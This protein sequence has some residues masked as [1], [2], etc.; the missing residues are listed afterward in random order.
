[1]VQQFFGISPSNLEDPDT[2]A[3]LGAVIQVITLACSIYQYVMYYCR[4]VS[5]R[6]M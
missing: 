6:G 5:C 2:A 1:M 4:E 3:A